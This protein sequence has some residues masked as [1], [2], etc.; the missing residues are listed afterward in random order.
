MSSMDMISL[1][2]EV[3][4]SFLENVRR[5]VPSLSN[6]VKDIEEVRAILNDLSPL[7]VDFEETILLA[8]RENLH[9]G[10][11][12]K[13]GSGKVSPKCVVITPSTSPRKRK[14]SHQRTA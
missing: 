11:T 13:L 14:R 2:D 1:P 12:K 8:C 7:H 10:N 6:S 5:S 4:Q 3:Y 9:D